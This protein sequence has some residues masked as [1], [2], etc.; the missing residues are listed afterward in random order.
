M[1][2]R[3]DLLGL[4]VLGDGGNLTLGHLGFQQLEE[5][6][7]GRSEGWSILVQKVCDRLGHPSASKADR[8]EAEIRLG[9]TYH[10]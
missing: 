6:R 4:D 9:S 7:H 3:N 5:D 2:I 8:S 1:F 10:G